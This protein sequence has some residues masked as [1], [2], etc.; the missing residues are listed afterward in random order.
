MGGGGG[1]RLGGVE[2]KEEEREE[3]TLAPVVRLS[4]PK[5][6]AAIGGR[7]GVVTGGMGRGEE[8]G[9]PSREGGGRS[10]EDEAKLVGGLVMVRPM[11]RVRGEMGEGVA[12]EEEEVEEEEM[13]V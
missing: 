7:E 3:E 10:S 5:C 9:G 12:E 2:D 11:V 4:E 8:G 1:G 13:E 6:L